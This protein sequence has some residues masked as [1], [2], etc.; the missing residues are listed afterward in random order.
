MSIQIRFDLAS[1]SSMF[2]NS[3][4]IG[5]VHLFALVSALNDWA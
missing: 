2:E 1:Q 3:E 5:I 4:N